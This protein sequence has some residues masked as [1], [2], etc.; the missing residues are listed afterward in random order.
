MTQPIFTTRV[1]CNY[2]GLYVWHK[3]F[4]MRDDNRASIV[5]VDGS[6]FLY[7]SSINRDWHRHLDLII[8]L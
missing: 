1:D 8:P 2:D 3:D 5:N 6:D 4:I 7:Y